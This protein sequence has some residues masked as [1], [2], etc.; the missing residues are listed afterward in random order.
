[1]AWISRGKIVKR[2]WKWKGQKRVAYVFDVMVDGR[3][4]RK[5]Y[6]GKQEAQDEL[7]KFRD[8]AKKNKVAIAGTCL[9]ILHRNYLKNDKLGQKWVADSIPITKAL[10]GRVILLPFFGKGALQTH[11]ELD[12]VGD[13]LKEIGP[14][15][16][17]VRLRRYG[18]RAPRA[19]AVR[20]QAGSAGRTGQIPRRCQESEAGHRRTDACAD[21]CGGVREVPRAEI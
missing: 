5:Q 15:A 4:V 13:F 12:F 11:E 7:D 18:R 9:N 19:K 14:E 16:R 3:R 10:G 2:T 8:E 6:A 17:G 21:A 20:R 1:M